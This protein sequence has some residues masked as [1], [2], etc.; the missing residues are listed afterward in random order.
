MANIVRFIHG[1][2]LKAGI[3]TDAGK[4]GCSMYPDLGPVYQHAGSEGHYEQDFLQFAKWG[5]D[6]VKVDWCGG[7]KENLDPAVQYAEIA[8]AIARAEATTGHHLYLLH[9]QLGQEQPLD[10]GAERGR[11]RR[12]HLAHQRRHRRAHRASITSTRTAR[13]AF[14]ACSPTSTRAFILKRSTPA[15]TTIPT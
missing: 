10:L 2:G 6:Y 7:D 15:S 3:Y 1:L 13:P 4:D 8:R 5:F 12:R 11:R 9:L 14:P